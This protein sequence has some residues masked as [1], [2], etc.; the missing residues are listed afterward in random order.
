MAFSTA[1]LFNTTPNFSS[2]PHF[3]AN[4]APTLTPILNT[5]TTNFSF[6][7]VIIGTPAQTPSSVEFQPQCVKNPPIA[8][9]DKISTCGAQPRI[10]SPLPLVLSINPSS[11]N[12]F[13]NSCA[14]FPSFITQMKG[15]LDAS[16][17][18]P[19][20]ISCRGVSLLRLPKHA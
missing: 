1:S 5:C 3:T 17:A 2:S 12:I 6:G 19:S 20:S 15:R 8:G 9:C 18:N 4:S 10:K 14:F 16:R 11:N 13:S 7:H